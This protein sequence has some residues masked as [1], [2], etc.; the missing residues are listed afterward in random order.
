MD[1]DVKYVCVHSKSSECLNNKCDLH[2]L[3]IGCIIDDEFV[4]IVDLNKIKFIDSGC[5][6]YMDN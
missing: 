6:K 4:Y 3:N 5:K 2:I 1:E